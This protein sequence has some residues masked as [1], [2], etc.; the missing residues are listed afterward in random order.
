MKKLVMVALVLALMCSSSGCSTTTIGRANVD[1]AKTG[2]AKVGEGKVGEGKRAIGSRG[3][4]FSVSRLKAGAYPAVAVGTS[5]RQLSSAPQP[6]KTALHQAVRRLGGGRLAIVDDSLV[7]DDIA[8]ATT[9]GSVELSWK[10]ES[11]AYTYAVLRDERRLGLV[12]GSSGY[13]RD[14]SVEP[15][16]SY[17]YRVTPVSSP[18]AERSWG[19]AVHVPSP[20]AAASSG[21]ALERSVAQDARAALANPTTTLTWVAFIRQARI[22]GPWVP[23]ACRYGAR[24]NYGGDNH[25]FDWRSSRYRSVINALV[26]WDTRTVAAYPSVRPTHVYRRST[27]K[28]VAVKTASAKFLKARAVGGGDGYVYIAMVHHASNPFCRLGAIDGAINI[29]ISR[30]G[31]WEI[32]SGLAHR[33]PDHYIFI[34]HAGHVTDVWKARALSTW[35]LTGDWHCDASYLTG[36]RGS[37]SR[38]TSGRL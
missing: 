31:T 14:A 33:M 25:G 38:R 13:F 9:A 15:G 8:T 10:P 18:Q 20:A 28:L 19:T 3:K 27:G 5:G 16:R 11:P 1:K 7:S 12:R 29:K 35:C 26:N 22:R 24:Y 23:H 4:R 30:S 17:A 21:D 32:R 34:Y 36:Y 6:A 2:E 37:Y